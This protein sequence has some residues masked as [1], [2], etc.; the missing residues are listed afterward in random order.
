MNE[1]NIINQNECV[2]RIPPF[3]TFFFLTFNVKCINLVHF[4]SKKRV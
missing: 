2:D 1:L 4:E 3:T